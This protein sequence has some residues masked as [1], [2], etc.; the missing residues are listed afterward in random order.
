[1]CCLALLFTVDKFRDCRIESR[2]N[3]AARRLLGVACGT[4]PPLLAWPRRHPH[5]RMN[6]AQPHNGAPRTRALTAPPGAC[7]SGRR[8]TTRPETAFHYREEVSGG[9]PPSGAPPADT[10]NRPDS[11]SS[12]RVRCH[13]RPRRFF[14]PWPDNTVQRGACC[15]SGR[16]LYHSKVCAQAKLFGESP[17]A[18]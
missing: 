14:R 10:N 1:M 3:G 5:P 12:P 17:Y 15:R 18:P 7:E 2:C 13:N 11:R 8:R 16:S 6:A 9:K 4:F